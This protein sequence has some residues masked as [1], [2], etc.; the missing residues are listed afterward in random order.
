L[1][2]SP[3]SFSPFLLSIEVGGH[4]TEDTTW[5][6]ENN[7]YIVVDNIFIDE[8]VTLTIEPGTIV[9]FNTANMVNGDFY[10]D[11]GYTEA[12][13]MLVRGKLAAVG[14]K[15]D[16]IIFTRNSEED[17]QR[18][19][20]IIFMPESDSTS[21][22]KHCKFEYSHFIRLVLGGAYYAGAV[23][24][25]NAKA[26][27]AKCLFKNFDNFY[28]APYCNAIYCISQS[29][30]IIYKN[31]F[32]RDDNIEYPGVAVYIVWQNNSQPQIFYNT[33]INVPGIYIAVLN[34]NQ[35]QITVAYNTFINSSYGIIS[36]ESNLYIYKNN[37]YN[38]NLSIDTYNDTAIIKQNI[39]EGGGG[40]EADG[41]ITITENTI[42]NVGG[43]ILT[44]DGSHC[45]ISNNVIANNGAGIYNSE[46]NNYVYNNL[47]IYNEGM[48]IVDHAF[49][50][51]FANNVIAY[52][53]EHGFL[54]SGST[55]LLNNILWYNYE[56]DFS[57]DY[58]GNISI[59]YCCIE[60]G[61]PEWA[62]DLG[63]NI[64]ENPQFVDPE[65]GDFHLLPISPC[66]D[67]GTPDT[68][69]YFIPPFDLDYA[70]RIWDGDNNG[71]AIIDMGCYEFGAMYIGGIA[72][73]VTLNNGDGF[74]PLT[75]IEINGK[76]AYP[77]TN[78][79]YDVNLLL[80][81]Y[82]LTATLEGYDS[83]IISDIEILEGEVTIVNFEMNSNVGVDDNIVSD[84]SG[85]ELTNYPNPVQT[86]TTIS[87][88]LR[89]LADAEKVELKIY[90]IKGQLV[91]QFKIQNYKL[92][93]NEVVWDGK[94]EN[95]KPVANG[96]YF[97]KLSADRKELIKK[98]IILR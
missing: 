92:K 97:C 76:I 38:C 33:F 52:N 68:T 8:N 90:N 29:S 13:F 25:S 84:M 26:T 78:G 79:Y 31:I 71:D 58:T 3:F 87:F 30:P 66:I 11:D 27:I 72:G 45:I 59:G 40:I 69:G 53:G 24:F 15:Q 80:G 88:S 77:D 7:P 10:Y 73:Q 35:P 83:V 2:Y 63:G 46:S 1:F 37:F 20:I 17:D 55:Q 42:T 18:W 6:P 5:S 23:S 51:F 21:I 43:A 41:T 9:K 19:G 74:V 65:N 16:S 12:K 34:P 47:I 75:R 94:D 44:W 14:T 49:N 86:S 57:S 32:T 48:G 62:T 81:V 96:L 50:T 85:F 82:E 91:K 67:T 56:G 4:L 22:F 64:T 93:I 89:Q 61:V 54:N 36:D 39:I 98:M 28:Q 60:D 70:F 95:G